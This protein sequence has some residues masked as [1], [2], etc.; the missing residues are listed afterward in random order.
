[1]RKIF[2]FPILILAA[3]SI[4][5]VYAATTEDPTTVPAA[6]TL[7]PV[8]VVELSDLHTKPLIEQL[9]LVDGALLTKIHKFL[10]TTDTN[11]FNQILTDYISGTSSIPTSTISIGLN[12]HQN[13]RDNPVHYA[14][15]HDF[16]LVVENAAECPNRLSRIVDAFN[17]TRFEITD[18]Q[19]QF[20]AMLCRAALT[21]T[22][23]KQAEDLIAQT[24]AIIASVKDGTAISTRTVEEYTT[25]I[26]SFKRDNSVGEALLRSPYPK[27]PTILE[28]KN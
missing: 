22:Y 1:M 20:K 4:N 23:M 27:K 26:Q 12:P 15:M 28:G 18:Q 2:K 5:N 3:L 21:R 13:E 24:N 16:L 6:K 11:S 7:P 8:K 19:A 10:G 9:G 14:L 25:D 17:A